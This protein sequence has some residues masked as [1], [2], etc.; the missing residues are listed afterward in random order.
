VVDEYRA[1]GASTTYYST[2]HNTHLLDPTS[3]QLKHILAGFVVPTITLIRLVVL[4]FYY[5][6]IF[7][8]CSA[9]CCCAVVLACCCLYVLRS[10]SRRRMI[11][12]NM[13]SDIIISIER[14]GLLC[15]HAVYF[16]L[17]IICLASHIQYLCCHV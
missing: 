13:M 8:C 10:S 16:L 11:L 2:T 14:H 1:A 4:L 3:S 15:M 7:I 17:I 6:Y 12:I 9:C 5:Y